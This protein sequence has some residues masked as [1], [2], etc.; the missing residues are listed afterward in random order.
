MNEVTDLSNLSLADNDLLK[1]Q[2]KE[3]GSLYRFNRGQVQ[4]L[5]TL[6]C[7]QNARRYQ[8]Y[9]PQVIQQIVSDALVLHDAYA[10]IPQGRYFATIS[11]PFKEDVT[12]EE[13]EMKG[14]PM[15]WISKK[16]F[17]GFVLG[18]L[19]FKHKGKKVLRFLPDREVAIPWELNRA[20]VLHP[21]PCSSFYQDTFQIGSEG[22]LIAHLCSN[23]NTIDRLSLKIAPEEAKAEVKSLRDEYH[24]TLEE[25]SD[26]R[27]TN[28]NTWDDV[29]NWNLAQI[30]QNAPTFEVLRNRAYCEALGMVPI[31]G[32]VNSIDELVGFVS[33]FLSFE[34]YGDP[35]SEEAYLKMFK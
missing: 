34:E 23:Y 19:T 29:I 10:S 16:R 21:I 24:F 28:F 18:D 15:E 32:A 14:S 31:T 7:E 1:T 12:Y 25:L 22:D 6:F 20:R 30:P 3:D 33:R 26:A 17:D 4:R 35:Y 8:T 2:G 11:Q 13:V 27:G 5:V 9:T